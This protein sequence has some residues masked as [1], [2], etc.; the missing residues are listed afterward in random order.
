MMQGLYFIN[1]YSFKTYII[2]KKNICTSK[3]CNLTKYIYYN[4]KIKFTLRNITI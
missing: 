1:T 4:I 3:L 2:L